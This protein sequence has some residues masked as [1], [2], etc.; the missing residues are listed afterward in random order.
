M[1]GHKWYL[2]IGELTDAS[3]LG[4]MQDANELIHCTYGMYQGIDF[5]GQAQTN[6]RVGDRE[7]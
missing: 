1:F 2:R 6:V 5:K 4:L 3:I 7:L